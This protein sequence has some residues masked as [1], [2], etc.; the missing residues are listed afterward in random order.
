M[1][2]GR[3]VPSTE[4]CVSCHAFGSRRGGCARTCVAVTCVRPRFSVAL[5]L[6]TRS[7][8]GPLFPAR[9][10]KRRASKWSDIYRTKLADNFLWPCE[11]AHQS[12]ACAHRY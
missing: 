9:A 7:W 10:S 4:S 1:R 6:G 12:L 2:T 3:R 11:W 5:Q 8:D